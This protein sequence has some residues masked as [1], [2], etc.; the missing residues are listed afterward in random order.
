MFYKSP[1]QDRRGAVFELFQ[2]VD[3][4]LQLG[5]VVQLRQAGG[6]VIGDGDPFLAIG[7]RRLDAVRQL[8]A[9]FAGLFFLLVSFVGFSGQLGIEITDTRWIWP[10]GLMVLGVIVLV[11]TG[12]RRDDAPELAASQD[13][14]TTAGADVD[15]W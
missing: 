1:F 2:G 7:D 14:G 10:I 8:E 12:M 4:C 6:D 15:T 13:D 5:G 3:L 11:G 9:A